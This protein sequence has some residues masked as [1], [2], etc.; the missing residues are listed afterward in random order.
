[1][2]GTAKYSAWLAV[3]L[4]LATGCSNAPGPEGQTG[5]AAGGAPRDEGSADGA[6]RDPTGGSQGS[7][8]E[9]ASG[10]GQPTGETGTQLAIVGIVDTAFDP[11]QVSIAS[12]GKV[13]WKQTGR[14]PHSVTAVDGS[15]DSH[16]GC[17][18]VAIED[19]ASEGDAFGHSFRKPGTYEYYCR[20]HGLPDGTGMAATVVVEP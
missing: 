8:G 18:P 3:T 4:L 1:M 10:S 13:V 2:N 16:P 11:E 12:G 19:C 17:G 15:F 9:R 5:K 14:Q 7:K 20:V 6:S